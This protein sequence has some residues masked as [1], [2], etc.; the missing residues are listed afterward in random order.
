MGGTSFEVG[1]IV[2]GQPTLASQQIIEKYTFH[3]THLDLRSIACGGGSIAHIDHESGGLR[4][5]PQSAGSNPGPA[6]YGRGTEATVTDADIVLGLLDPETFLGGR[7]RLDVAAARTAVGKV[8]KRLGLSVE[9]TAA[10]IVQVNAHAAASLIRQRTIEQGLDPRDFTVYAFGG[11]GPVHAFAYASELGIKRVL[12]PL[13]NGASTLSAYGAAVGDLIQSFEKP[14]LLTSPFDPGTLAAS[15]AVLEEKA[16]AAMAEAGTADGFVI[17]RMASMRYAGQKL[18]ELNI[19]LPDGAID[20]ALCTEMER[21][22]TAEYARLY[23]KAA[24]ALFQVIEI[25]NIRVTARVKAEIASSAPA[26]DDARRPSPRERMREVYW[27]G[28]GLRAT[29]VLLGAL[30]PDQQISGPAIVE[31][32]H[33]SISIA[34]GQ[35]LRA[36]ADDTLILE[37]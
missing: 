11:A 24:L 33:T 23:S 7:M 14:L 30:D 5:G 19:R 4:V 34:P 18:Q 32:R 13:G 36:D 17:E 12:V 9:E 37:L 27:P 21:R 1:L 28:H 29:R 20:A 6:C 31:L 10:G 25:F 16:R 15:V 35:R 8:A 26:S 2:D 3:S 22:F